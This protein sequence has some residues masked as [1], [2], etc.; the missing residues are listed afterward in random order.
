MDRSVRWFTWYNTHMRTDPILIELDGRGRAAVGR[1]ARHTRY[2]VTVASDGTI[3][4]T[5]AIVVSPLEA[6]LLSQR[7]DLLASLPEGTVTRRIRAERS[8]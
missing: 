6:A 2:T 7:P 3:T 8:P 1:V 5:P 4:L